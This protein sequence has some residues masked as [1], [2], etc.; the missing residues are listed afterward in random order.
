[1][2]GKA[3]HLNHK[4]YTKFHNNLKSIYVQTLADVGGNYS[5]TYCAF[6]L[7]DLYSL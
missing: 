1:M 2:P 6:T 4:D 3:D 7:V 5:L